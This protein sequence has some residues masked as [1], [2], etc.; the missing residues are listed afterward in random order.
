MIYDS[1]YSDVNPSVAS[2]IE[3]LFSN[4]PLTFKMAVVGKQEGGI[5]CGVLA[6]ANATA[7]PIFPNSIKRKFV[8]I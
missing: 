2:A 1:S 7:L 5:D 3:R 8:L 6:I 4:H